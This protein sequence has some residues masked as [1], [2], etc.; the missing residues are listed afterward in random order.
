MEGE[1]DLHGKWL[2]NIYGIQKYD[3]YLPFAQNAVI[4]EGKHYDTFNNC[5]GLLRYQYGDYWSLPRAIMQQHASEFLDYTEEDLIFLK[6][7]KG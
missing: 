3:I 1:G 6:K 7:L 2:R 4:F 5:D